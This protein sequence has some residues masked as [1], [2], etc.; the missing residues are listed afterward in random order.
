MYFYL[1]ISPKLNLKWLFTDTHLT[2]PIL[3]RSIIFIYLLIYYSI[4]SKH[5]VDIYLLTRDLRTSS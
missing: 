2:T 4:S 3:G 5:K 1:F